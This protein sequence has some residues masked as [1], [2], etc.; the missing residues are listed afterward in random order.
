MKTTA[1]PSSPGRAVM[2]ASDSVESIAD[3]LEEVRSS[4]RDH[5]DRA[6][7]L[8]HTITLAHQLSSAGRA[9]FRLLQET[10]ERTR[11]LKLSVAH[12]AEVLATL[13]RQL[14]ELT[15]KNKP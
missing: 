3:S 7:S 5:V 1:V 12:Q 11:K 9:Q 15:Q 10:L 14:A 4:L 6:G 2:L 13:R 8:L